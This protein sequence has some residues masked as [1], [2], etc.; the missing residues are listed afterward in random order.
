MTQEFLDR[1]EEY[2]NTPGIDSGKARSYVKS[3]EY[4]CDYLSIT[5]IDTRSV[6]KMK[7]AEGD[8]CVEGSPFYQNLLV[9]L[10]SRGQSSYLKRGFIRAALKIFFEFFQHEN[11]QGKE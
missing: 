1:F 9:F 5:E 11:T 6:S 4:L 3:I 7:H 8:I 2:C 10:V